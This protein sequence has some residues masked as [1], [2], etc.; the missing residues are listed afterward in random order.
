MIRLE[1][2]K[3]RADAATK[4]PWESTDGYIYLTE[5]LSAVLLHY[6]K[7]GSER[8]RLA[9]EQFIAHARVDIPRLIQA[10]EFAF[11]HCECEE[12]GEECNYCDLKHGMN[13]FIEHGRLTPKPKDEG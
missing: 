11:N 12:I 5:S 8:E 9:T 2:I 10:I 6:E 13:S 3:S 7:H 1:E 4:G